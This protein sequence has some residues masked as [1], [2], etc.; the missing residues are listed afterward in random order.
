MTDT[1][2]GERADGRTRFDLHE[3]D[4]GSLGDPRGGPA[5][6]PQAADPKVSGSEVDD[7]PLPDPLRVVVADDHPMWR[8]AV[9]RDLAHAGFSVV[10]TAADGP[11]AVSR[12][13]AAKPHVLVLDLNLPKLR[14]HEVCA[15]LTAAGSTTRILILSVSGEAAD[16]LAAVKAGA[17]GYL[18]K[19][20]G[21]AEFLEAVRRTAAGRAV[22]TPGLADL[23]LAEFRRMREASTLAPERTPQLTERETEVLRLVARGMTYR[24]VAAELFISHRTVQNHVQN[25]L[26][27]LQMHNRVELVRYVLEQGLD[28]DPRR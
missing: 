1:P 6:R 17:T 7:E 21:R 8:D 16:V 23:V 3:I 18:V 2:A 19:S 20:A 4:A 9:A 25:S 5:R 28:V 22:F 27:K 11:S 24:D 13:L 12:T 26:T 10:G 14:G 15:Q